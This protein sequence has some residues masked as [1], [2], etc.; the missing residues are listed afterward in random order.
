MKK[1]LLVLI[2]LVSIIGTQQSY[3]QNPTNFDMQYTIVP[4]KKV[5]VT[6]TLNQVEYLNTHQVHAFPITYWCF[7][8]ASPDMYLGP[9]LANPNDFIT[10][11]STSQTDTV[12]FDIEQNCADPNEYEFKYVVIGYPNNDTAGTG[13]L[14]WVEK[15]VHISFPPNMGIDNADEN[16][17]IKVYPNP[18]TDVVTIEGFPL[19]STVTLYDPLGRAVKNEVSQSDRLVWQTSELASGLYTIR[20]DNGAVKKLLID[21]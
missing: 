17:F 1:A 7:G 14:F 8:A 6:V 15:I 12:H 21:H 18:S 20:F 16:A 9:F 10:N 19:G 2:F 5:I 4:G 11:T 13:P 3:A